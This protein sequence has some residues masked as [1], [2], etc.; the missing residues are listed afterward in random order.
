MKTKTIF[1]FLV[2]GLLLVSMVSAE[3]LSIQLKRTNPGIAKEKAAELIFDVVNT[4]FTHKVEGF[5]LCRSPDDAVVSSTLGVG[6]GS[7]AQYVSPKFIMDTGPAQKAI[8][9]TIEADNRGD[10]RTGCT[11]RYAPYKEESGSSSTETINYEGTIGKTETDVSGF[12]V[13]LVSYSAGS[14]DT[15]AMA[16]ISVND[17]PKDMEV[18]SEA[19]VGGLKITL[20]AAIEE[21]ADVKITGEKTVGDE[22]TKKYLKMNGQYTTSL[23]DDE[24]REIRV[25]K[26]VPFVAQGEMYDPA[27]PDGQSS[28]NADNLIDLKAGVGGIKLG[29]ILGAIAVIVIV[30]VYLLGK[31]AGKRRDPYSL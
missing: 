7:G 29:W 3:G 28:C 4:D 27:C 26:T 6:S 31:S 19:T 8:S 17:I 10:K 21:S 16:R 30:I 9:L 23:S 18:G 14:N 11:I 2:M 22:V 13:K 24:Y 25:D 1:L 20:D 12:K 15:V 5:L